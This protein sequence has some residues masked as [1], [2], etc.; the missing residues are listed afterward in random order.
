LWDESETHM[1]SSV[2]KTLPITVEADQEIG[3]PPDTHIRVRRARTVSNLRVLWENRRSIGRAV[4]LGFTLSTILAFVLPK[5]YEATAQIMPPDNQTGAL[6]ALASLTG[7]SSMGG[8]GGL[9]GDV[10]GAKTTSATFIGILQSRTVA[11]RLIAQFNLQKIYSAR[12][13]EDARKA[14][15]SRTDIVE[16]R[17]SGIISLTVTDKDPVRATAM[18]QA[19]V[20]ELDR[21]VAQLATS[22][23][24]RQR[25][26]LE[27]RLQ[28]VKGELES[29]EVALSNFS[30]KNSTLDI[31]EQGKAMLEAAARVQ[32]ELIASETE[33]QGLR[34][35]YADTNVR[36]RAAQ[37]RVK[38]LRRKLNE[39]GGSAPDAPPLSSEGA[40][41]DFTYPSIRQLPALGVTY[42]D[43]YRR[44][45]IAE[46]VYELLTREY[47]IAKL[48]EAKEIPSVKE[49]DVPV[50]PQSK[51]FPPR[52]VIVLLGTFLAFVMAV[53][54]I[55]GKQ[56]WDETE[57][58]DPG[59]QLFGE[60]FAHTRDQVTKGQVLLKR[61]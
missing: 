45:R 24:R 51:S 36:V 57:P 28:G 46:I 8:L 26:F 11:D 40:S 37:A 23:A 2:D 1:R 22:A 30:S 49:L 48:N 12:T 4:I 61:G 59:K 38:E 32:A 55:Y 27:G 47:E 50:L 17:K 42:A 35:M 14:L 5:T 54:W 16:D 18:A 53:A 41:S 44:S 20:N 25:E 39:V 13:M 21:L 29:A 56:L 10:L 31:R 9:M 6:A 33:L 15:R 60:I 52:R 3:L 34:Q 43:L 7:S 19:Y 58:N